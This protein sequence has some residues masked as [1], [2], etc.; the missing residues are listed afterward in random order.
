MRAARLLVLAAL[1]ALT[2]TTAAQARTHG[3]AYGPGDV[4][5]GRDQKPNPIRTGSR[6]ELRKAIAG[7][8]RRGPQGLEIGDT[9]LWLAYDDANGFD[10]LKLFE[11]RGI[12]EH[13]EVW[14][15]ADQDEVS[16]G[17]EFLPGDCRNNRVEITDAQVQYLI[18]EFDTNIYP[19]AS[20]GAERSTSSRRVGID[21]RPG[22]GARAAGGLLPGRRRQDRR[23]D[24]QLPRLELLQLQS[25]GSD[26]HDVHRRLLHVVLR[27][28]V[29]PA[30]DEHRP[31]RLAAPNGCES[32]A[33][34]GSQRPLRERAPPDRFSTKAS[35]RT[36]TS[37]S[38]RTTRTRTSTRG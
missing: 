8:L 16:T 38:S 21:P 27:R 25:R 11:L 6:A 29:R 31:V 7:T 30:R 33:R 37:T 9:R 26:R 36:S 4:T 32:S 17:L 34:A 5:V 3:L 13:I 28:H 12:G 15:A 10:Y 20:Q 1:L 22:P 14:V 2:M 35:S 24:R 19:K 23:A 18:S